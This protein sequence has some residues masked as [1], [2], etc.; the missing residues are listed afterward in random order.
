MQEKTIQLISSNCII[1]RP[2]VEAFLCCICRYDNDDQLSKESACSEPGDLRIITVK[3]ERE[4]P[5]DCLSTE[6][7]DT[8]VMLW[9]SI[10]MV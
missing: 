10:C 5:H 2:F 9:G 3:D 1:W 4:M 8:L 6:M 7:D